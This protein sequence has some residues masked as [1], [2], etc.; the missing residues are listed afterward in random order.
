M[1]RVAGLSGGSFEEAT[2][3]LE[4]SGKGGKLGLGLC[5]LVGAGGQAVGEVGDAVGV[6]G[7]AG[8]DTLQL[9]GGL[10]GLGTRFSDLLIERVAVADA[11][12][13]LGVHGFDGRGL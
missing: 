3:L 2:V 5:E 13:V 7:C 12:A 9:D 4:F 11:F 1:A 8:C 10:I 6:G